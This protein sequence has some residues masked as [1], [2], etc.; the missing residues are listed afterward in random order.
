MRGPRNTHVRREA[1]VEHHHLWATFVHCGAGDVQFLD[2][3]DVLAQ[4]FEVAKRDRAAL[5][6]FVGNGR[7]GRLA[8][9]LRVGADLVQ[10]GFGR[11]VANDF[12]QR[13]GFGL[14]PWQHVENQLGEAANLG[15]VFVRQI[16]YLCADA[17]E[18]L[19][20]FMG[21]VEQ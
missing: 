1:G 12:F 2:L 11:L 10:N 18:Q 16:A 20:F 17:L 15:Q 7:N 19:V 14:N 6:Q 4:Q 9:H 21:A 5:L 13:Q 8:G 3:R